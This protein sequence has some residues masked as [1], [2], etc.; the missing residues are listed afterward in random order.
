MDEKQDAVR[1]ENRNSARTGARCEYCQLPSPLHSP[2]FQIDHII[3]KQ[4]GGTGGLDNL[5]LAC[6]HCNR[7]KGPSLAGIDSNTGELTRLFHPRK[8]EWKRHF[9]WRGTEILPLG[10]IGRVTISVLFMNDPELL[11]LRSTLE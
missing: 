9:Q 10:P 3:A 8:D 4:H 1:F 11:W 2:P 7:Y 6:I 5:A